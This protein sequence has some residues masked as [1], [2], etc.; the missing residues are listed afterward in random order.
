MISAAC[1]GRCQ[2]AV[3]GNANIVRNIIRTQNRWTLTIAA[4]CARAT[5]GHATAAPPRSMIKSRRLK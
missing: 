5:I 4:Y 1:E 2:N 3:V